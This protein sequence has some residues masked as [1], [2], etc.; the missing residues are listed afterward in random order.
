MCGVAAGDQPPLVSFHSGVNHQQDLQACLES[1]SLRNAACCC[2]TNPLSAANL[3][4]WRC[5][6]DDDDDGSLPPWR[7][8]PACLPPHPAASLPAL[9]GP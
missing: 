7:A 2:T 8:A 5:S 4:S 1:P 9:K 3:E 6:G